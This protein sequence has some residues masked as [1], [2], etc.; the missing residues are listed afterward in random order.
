MVVVPPRSSRLRLAELFPA[1]TIARR[2]SLLDRFWRGENPGRPIIAARSWGAQPP[3]DPLDHPFDTFLRR[4]L[5]AFHGPDCVPSF[6]CCGGTCTLASAWGGKVTRTPDGKVWI[7]PVVRQS[8]DVHRLPR[9]EVL[10]GLLGKA[11]EDY[12]R[13]LGSVDGYLPPHICDPQGP[14]MTAGMLWKEDEFIVAMFDHPKEVHHILSLVTDHIIAMYRYFRT[15]H[16]DANTN[17]YPGTWMPQDLGVGLV[18]DFCHLLS[19]DL[20]EEFG[21]PYVNRISDTF[22]GVF[23]HCCGA[24][25]QH[26]PAFHKI[27]NLRGLDTMY[28]FSKPE[29]VFAEFPA[30]VHS[31]GI[32]YAETQRNFRDKGSDGWLEYLLPRI[33]RCLRWQ[34]VVNVDEPGSLSRQLR[35]IEEK[36]R[37]Q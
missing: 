7:E 29:E 4:T 21:L 23:V 32:D 10:D 31:M 22:G 9:P 11:V 1:E 12:Q 17:C 6:S 26:W 28:P 13:F 37:R 35:L 3:G 14:L 16:K 25:K 24:F 5:S 33:P 18:E 27:C 8:E 34:F 20:Y 2:K 30:V 19:P 15:Q 36:W